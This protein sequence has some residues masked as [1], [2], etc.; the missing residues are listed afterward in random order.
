MSREG[1]RSRGKLVFLDERIKVVE[2]GGE[3]S[4]SGSEI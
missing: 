1:K 4:S 2:E 3:I